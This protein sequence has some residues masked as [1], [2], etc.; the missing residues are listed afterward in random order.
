MS[1]VKIAGRRLRNMAGEL[2]A[3]LA[4]VLTEGSRRLVCCER[5]GRSRWYS[6]ACR[7]STL[8]A[9]VSEPIKN[10]RGARR[11]R[12]RRKILNTGEDL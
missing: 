1:A 3:T 6:R 5:C 4:D 2:C 8:L 11:T 7:R 10:Q 9:W 12:P